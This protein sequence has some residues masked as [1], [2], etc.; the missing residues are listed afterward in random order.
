MLWQNRMDQGA[1]RSM[2]NS[3]VPFAL[4]L[5]SESA[6]V[7]GQQNAWFS[8]KLPVHF[9][10]EKFPQ[11]SV[12]RCRQRKQMP[13]STWSSH[14]LFYLCQSCSTLYSLWYLLLFA[15]LLM[16][17]RKV[18]KIREW[19]F[20]QCCQWLFPAIDFMLPSFSSCFVYHAATEVILAKYF[21]FLG[22]TYFFMHSPPLFYDKPFL[23]SE[24]SDSI[25]VL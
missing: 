11:R 12:F 16:L 5:T 24:T 8:H 23:V 3:F 17:R 6:Q 7:L 21:L 19:Q 13:V 10:I 15:A 20:L 2:C 14:F 4:V 9:V 22:T 25:E 1:I 18:L